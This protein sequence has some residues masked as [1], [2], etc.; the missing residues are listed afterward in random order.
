MNS[1]SRKSR[2]SQEINKL[3]FEERG[4]RNKSKFEINRLNNTMV[5]I[6]V[7]RD[8]KLNNKQRDKE[9]VS[10]IQNVKEMG[11]KS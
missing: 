9:G 1:N 6:K 10:E 5:Q 4:D 3:R 7:V 11:M 8:C 2:K